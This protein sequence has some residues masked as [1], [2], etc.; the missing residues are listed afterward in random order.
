MVKRAASAAISEPIRIE[1]FIA[2]LLI[3]A[4]NRVLAEAGMEHLREALPNTLTDF[5]RNLPSDSSKR[6]DQRC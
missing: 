6:G 5:A 1:D 2:K 4:G 3:S